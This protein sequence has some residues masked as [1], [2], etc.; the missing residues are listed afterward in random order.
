MQDLTKQKRACPNWQAL[1]L[2]KTAAAL[3]KNILFCD[4]RNNQAVRN[5]SSRSD[6]LAMHSTLL[7]TQTPLTALLFRQHFSNILSA[8]ASDF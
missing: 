6:S 4:L 5:L 8:Y 1:F 3:S 7:G 2:G